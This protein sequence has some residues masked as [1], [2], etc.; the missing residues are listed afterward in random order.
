MIPRLG[1]ILWLFFF[2]FIFF[3]LNCAFRTDLVIGQKLLIKSK[4]S[5]ELLE[6]L[7]EISNCKI[8]WFKNVSHTVL[9]ISNVPRTMFFG[10]CLRK[11]L[12]KFVAIKKASQ[13]GCCYNR[14]TRINGFQRYKSRSVNSY[15]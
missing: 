8:L 1:S 10:S 5:F 12:K 13:T 15:G 6:Y 11:I 2:F 3:E 9:V 14:S 4:T 7:N